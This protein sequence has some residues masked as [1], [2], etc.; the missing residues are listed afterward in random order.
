[1]FEREP[2]P[3]KVALRLVCAFLLSFMGGSQWFVHNRMHAWQ[4]SQW[5]HVIRKTWAYTCATLV[6]THAKADASR[7][8][9]LWLQETREIREKSGDA[10]STED[11]VLPF[12]KGWHLLLLLDC[13]FL[14]FSQDG[15]SLCASCMF[16]VE[17]MSSQLPVPAMPAPCC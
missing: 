17:D 1:M 11:K 15:S 8:P 9:P 10:H 2:N 6:H 3:G 7:S 4:V 5:D 14:D 16:V 12:L 13:P